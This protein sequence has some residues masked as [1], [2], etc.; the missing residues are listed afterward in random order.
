MAL[1]GVLALVA[2]ACSDDGGDQADGG[3]TTVTVAR[4]GPSSNARGN[5]DG[6]LVIGKLL[7]QSG[8]QSARF[9][10]VDTPINIAIQ[11][12]NA[13]GGVNGK[14][15]TLLA[16]DD[17]TRADVAGVS[18]DRLLHERVDVVLGPSSSAT[19]LGIIDKVE[20]GEVVTCSGSNT[21]AELTGADSGG[22]YLRTAPPDKLQGPALAQLVINDGHTR[23]AILT[24][25]DSYGTGFGDA[26]QTA[27][28]N[29]D[30][31]VVLNVP[32]DA[33]ATDFEADVRAVKAVAPDAIVV[34]GLNED[35][36]R[37]V[38][39]M[40]AQGLG[41]SQVQIYTADGMQGSSFFKGV[42]PTNPGIVKDIRGTAPAA[43]PT[44]I[45]HPFHA[46]YAKTGQDTIFS[47]HYYDC[48]L[49][50]ALAAQ[51]AGSDD[52]GLIRDEILEVSKGGET[53]QTF[54]DCLALLE[55]G[56]DIDYDGASGPVDLDDNREPTVGVYDVW[57][58]DASGAPHNVQ[59]VAQI[60]IGG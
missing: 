12:I 13:A 40:V 35:G 5:V 52:P 3:T 46:E 34:I 38:K 39:E 10:A 15:I 19:M 26:L 57:A 18:L 42:D 7:P 55:D 49:L 47:S 58:Y 4:G 44:G 16:A 23:V 11:E 21:A 9:K 29:Q 45:V 50:V 54:A 28:Q 31:D 27:L 36:S 1:L 25:D 6:T 59:G 51:A 17:G 56:Q 22:Y 33:D 8:D 2:A 60:K 43:A 53:C 30:T 37:I 24:R 32:Y 20:S 48:T 14:P 41:P